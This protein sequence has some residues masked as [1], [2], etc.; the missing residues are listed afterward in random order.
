MATDKLRIKIG[1]KWIEEE[2]TATGR[3][4][5]QTKVASLHQSW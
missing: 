4:V 5:S 1:G 2:D 3:V